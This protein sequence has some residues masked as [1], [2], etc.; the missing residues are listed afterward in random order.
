[1]RGWQ[2]V[3]GQIREF[4]PKGEVIKNVELQVVKN[5]AFRYFG[6]VSDRALL[7]P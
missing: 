3:T 6:V 1:M 2:G 7:E 4:T 5:S